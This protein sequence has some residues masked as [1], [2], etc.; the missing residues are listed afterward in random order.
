MLNVEF[1][2]L[3]PILY[4]SFEA[5]QERDSLFKSALDEYSMA[6]RSHVVRAYIEALTKGGWSLTESYVDIL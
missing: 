6:R 5:L 3:K 4:Q 2:E 1:L